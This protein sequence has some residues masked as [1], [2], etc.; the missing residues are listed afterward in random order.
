MWGEADYYGVSSLIAAAIG[1]SRSPL[2]T[3]TWVHGWIFRPLRHPEELLGEHFKS[4]YHLVA[5]D[6]QK[7]FLADRGYSHV[8]AVGSPFV[9]ADQAAGEVQRR[10]GTLLVLPPHSLPEVLI[11]TDQSEYVDAIVSIR[12]R[13][14]Q[15]VACVSQ[16]CVDHGF[17][18]PAF[19][20]AGIACITGASLND[21]NALVRMQRL[22]RSFEF[23]STNTIGSHVA[24]AAYCGSRVSIFGPFYGLKADYLREAPLYRRFPQ[25]LDHMDTDASEAVA[26]ER[27]PFLFVDPDSAERHEPWAAETLGASHRRTHNEIARMLGWTWTQRLRGLAPWFVNAVRHRM[28]RSSGS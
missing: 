26:R 20:A 28:T 24:Y 25:L 3:A 6:A 19:E 14:D 18:K 13:F 7:A 5:T 1:R 4:W 11:H 21:A 23:V 9:Y 10:S 2:S 22:F 12:D 17:W 27:F 16:S 8:H 15:V